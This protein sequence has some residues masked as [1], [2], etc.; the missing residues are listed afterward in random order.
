MNEN[1]MSLINVGDISIIIRNT[2]FDN[3]MRSAFE[4]SNAKIKTFE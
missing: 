2:Q 1:Q 3:N 4:N